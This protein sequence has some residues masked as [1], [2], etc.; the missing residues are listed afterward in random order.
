MRRY[1]RFTELGC[2]SFTCHATRQFAQR[3]P[4]N[5]KKTK[6][7]TQILAS[8]FIIHAF[9]MSQGCWKVASGC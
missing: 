4:I 8:T 6:Q 5:W 7:N 1:N 9:F 3:E 2:M